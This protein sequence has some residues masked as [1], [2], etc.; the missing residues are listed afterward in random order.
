VGER[1]VTLSGG[2][3]QRI[4]IARALLK[5]C[6]FAYGSDPVLQLHD[7]YVI[8]YSY[9]ML[10]TSARANIWESFPL[11]FSTKCTKEDP[12]VYACG[13]TGKLRIGLFWS[14]DCPIIPA[15][16]HSRNILSILAQLT[17]PFMRR[18]QKS[19]FWTKRQAPSTP[20]R[21]TLYAYSNSSQSH[22]HIVLARK[23][24]RQNEGRA[25]STVCFLMFRRCKKLSTACCMAAQ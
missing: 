13:T 25:D 12:R 10:W 9:K 2:Q 17:Y 7:Y 20:S 5:A 19:S 23:G 8:R 14:D 21:S 6:L 1:G 11:V 22:F 18:T 15:H 24:F 3:R 16:W 4:A